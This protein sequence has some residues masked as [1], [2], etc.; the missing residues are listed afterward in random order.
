MQFLLTYPTN[1]QEK[2][3]PVKFNRSEIVAF[4]LENLAK[5]RQATY[6]D[7]RIKEAKS[8]LAT[9]RRFRD[10]IDDRRKDIK[11][12]YLEPYKKFEQDL[13]EIFELL[14]GPINQIY[15]YVKSYEN[16]KKEAKRLEIEA[17]FADNIGKEYAELLPLAR[18][19]NVKW[20]NA[21]V[22]IKA[23]QKELL[24]KIESF[25]SGLTTL[26]GIINESKYKKQVLDKYIETLDAALA[27]RELERLS[28]LDANLEKIKQSEVQKQAEDR[29]QVESGKQ[30][31]CQVVQAPPPVP[32]PEK[33]EHALKLVCTDSQLQLVFD[34]CGSL[35][36][37][38]K[39]LRLVKRESVPMKI[40]RQSPFGK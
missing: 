28:L 27:L 26:D 7:T 4:L 15:A 34:Y 37:E 23:V 35:G 13:K 5:Y 2:L 36:I 24:E 10:A 14:E 16:N 3:A 20:E 17:F 40:V 18:I 9:L 25:K 12:Y 38:V 32:V 6:D 11:E 39:R 21:T 8:D 19:Y 30:G 1:L 22:N 33:L 31:E 29:K